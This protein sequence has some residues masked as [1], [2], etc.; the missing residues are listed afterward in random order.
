MF[1]RP[2][3]GAPPLRVRRAPG[4]EDSP[5]QD[6]RLAAEHRLDGGSARRRAQDPPAVHARH[7]ERGPLGD[8]RRGGNPAGSVLR[9][10]CSDVLPRCTAVH[11]RPAHHV[12][13]RGRLRRPGPETGRDVRRELRA[14]PGTRLPGS[15]GRRSAHALTAADRHG[16]GRAPFPYASDSTHGS[17]PERGRPAGRVGAVSALCALP[18]GDPAAFAPDVDP[19]LRDLQD[20]GAM[21][22]HQLPGLLPGDPSRRDVLPCLHCV[23]VYVCQHGKPQR[24]QGDQRPRRRRGKPFHQAQAPGPFHAGKYCTW[25]ATGRNKYSSMIPEDWEGYTG[26]G[27]KYFHIVS[28]PLSKEGQR[29]VLLTNPFRDFDGW[30]FGE[31]RSVQ[32]GK[33]PFDRFAEGPFDTLFYLERTA[34]A[35]TSRAGTPP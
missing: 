30:H 21:V 10:S 1:R 24:Q 17:Q 26:T 28:D 27:G 2:L 32:D 9:S 29:P 15:A 8:A 18:N 12:A 19:V 34:P 22:P 23:A 5:A 14:V 6:P 11:P 3:H 25:H 20:G 13:R 4:G 16:R 7:A 31:I 33:R 35:L